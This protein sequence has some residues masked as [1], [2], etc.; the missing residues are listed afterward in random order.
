[1]RERLV[2][3][4]KQVLTELF[5]PDLPKIFLTVHSVSSSKKQCFRRKHK[6]HKNK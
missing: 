2:I 1:M 5:A 6:H 4:G 3:L